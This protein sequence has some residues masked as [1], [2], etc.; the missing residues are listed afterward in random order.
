MHVALAMYEYLLKV[1]LHLV[2]ATLV[3]SRLTPY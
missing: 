2:L 1:C 3:L